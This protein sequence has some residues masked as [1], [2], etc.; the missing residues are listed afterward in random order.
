MQLR[1]RA[2]FIPGHLALVQLFSGAATPGPHAGHALGASHA[3]ARI[4]AVAVSVSASPS[5]GVAL[6]PPTRASSTSAIASSNAFAVLPP[7]ETVGIEISSG[8]CEPTQLSAAPSSKSVFAMMTA[9]APAAWHASVLRLN[10]HDPRATRHVA[11]RIFSG[12]TNAPHASRSQFPGSPAAPSNQSVDSAFS[13]ASSNRPG[14][15]RTSPR[16]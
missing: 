14:R 13:A 11:P 7:T 3:Y 5:P 1:V 8:S 12:S 16:T 4:V 15:F 6:G 9:T 10:G 2:S